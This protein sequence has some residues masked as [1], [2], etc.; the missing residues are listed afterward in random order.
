MEEIKKLKKQINTITIFWV[1]FI[2]VIIAKII[3]HTILKSTLV[4]ASVG[5]G[6]INSIN[7]GFRKFTISFTGEAAGYN[8]ISFF[9]L[10]RFLGLA[11]TFD[12]EIF[13]TIL[14]NF[15]LLLLFSKLKN[16]VSLLEFIFLC[17][18]V[19]VLNIWNF[20]LAKEPIQ[21]LYFTLIFYILMSKKLKNKSK[22]VLSLIV[23]FFSCITYR[24]YYILIFLFSICSYFIIDKFIVKCNKIGFKDIIKVI[25]SFGIIYMLLIIF[26][27]KYFLDYYN[28]FMNLNT[29]VT[30]AKTDLGGIFRSTNPIIATIDYIIL[31]IRML[32]PVELMHFGLS[33]II[34]AAYQIILTM[35][36]FKSFKNV[37]NNS[38]IENF[39]LYI[40]IGFLFVSG[41]FEPDFGSW[42]RH[43]A[44]T[45]PIIL[46]AT[47]L[48]RNDERKI[49][50]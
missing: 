50:T 22:F 18:S 27:K 8:T 48:I 24:N 6:Y 16:K 45:I 38:Y 14:W 30:G 17:M 31:I 11:T 13:I 39:A 20:C 9:G 47:R 35:L 42:I 34:Y 29:S 36:L 3:R 32:F 4:D 7:S 43:E 44:A 2:I 37:K 12:Y 49:C 28:Q 33:Y 46:I 19:A 10:F 21:I 15:L 5:D 25:L 1:Y 23:I 40:F 26:S 41:I